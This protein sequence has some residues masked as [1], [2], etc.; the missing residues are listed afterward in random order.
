MVKYYFFVTLLLVYSF[1]AVNAQ[2]TEDYAIRLAATVQQTPPQI[3]LTWP[4]NSSV[5][6]QIY[7][8]S[9]ESN[10]WGSIIA[11]VPST[12]TFYTDTHVVIDSAYE[13][14]VI[15]SSTPDTTG[16][17]YAGIAAPAIHNRGAIILL[18]D[19]VFT[20]T[21]KTQLY[22]MMKDISGDGWQVIRH[23]LSRDIHDTAIKSI[24]NKDYHTY[25]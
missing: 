4:R 25:T 2:T 3:T 17:I 20:D 11:T 22:Q 10:A 18:V 23:D 7:R 15:A 19:S 1:T 13:Y 14:Q 16:Y 21:C 9:K 24:I 5:S 6:Y 8:K 12:D